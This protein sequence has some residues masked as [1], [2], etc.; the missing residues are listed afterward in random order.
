MSA[1]EDRTRISE[2]LKRRGFEPGES[3]HRFRPEFELGDLQESLFGST[4]SLPRHLEMNI[5]GGV[6]MLRVV[7]D[8][9]KQFYLPHAHCVDDKPL[10]CYDYPE[11]YIE[12]WLLKSGF[13]PYG[14]VVRVRMFVQTVAGAFDTALIQRIPANPDPDGLVLVV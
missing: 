3:V 8:C 11:W 6:G 13:D 14:E 4:Y 12:G 9:V 5:G 7:V 1:G 2:D 10:G